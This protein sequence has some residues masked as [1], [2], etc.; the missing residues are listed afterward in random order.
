MRDG[1]TIAIIGAGPVGLS[2]GVYALDRGLNP[3]ILEAGPEVGYAVRQ[4]GH[5]RMFSSWEHNLDKAAER[6]LARAGWNRPE[7]GTYPT[8]ASL[9]TVTWPP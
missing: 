3:L 2:A 4:W 6:L 8:G 7:G 9:W 5:V 1:K